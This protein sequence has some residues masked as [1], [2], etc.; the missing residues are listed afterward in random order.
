MCCTHASPLYISILIWMLQ[1]NRIG[2]HANWLRSVLGDFVFKDGIG[3][4]LGLFKIFS[5]ILL[6][7]SHLR[8]SQIT[9][10]FSFCC[11]LVFYMLSGMI[12]W[13]EN[14]L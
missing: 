6:L 1:Q 3:I 14:L 4:I 8:S 12:L 9:K 10:K 13:D 11:L 5:R 7:N 2:Q